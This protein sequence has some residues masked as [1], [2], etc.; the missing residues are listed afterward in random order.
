MEMPIGLTGRRPDDERPLTEEGRRELKKIGEALRAAKVAPGLILTSPLPR[1]AETA[2]IVGKELG[3]P[4]RKETALE[5]GFA[6][7]QCRDLLA[8]QE[9]GDVMLV[10]HEPDF[11]GII[12]LLTGGDVKLPKA[13]AAAIELERPEGE[14][15]LLWLLPAKLLIRL[16]R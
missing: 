16:Y 10:G 12:A 6:G 2:E 13:G 1:A 7:R 3:A 14:G 15:R 8:A 11:S 4:V 9:P 5:P